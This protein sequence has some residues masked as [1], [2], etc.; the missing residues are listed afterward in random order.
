MDSQDLSCNQVRDLL[1]IAAIFKPYKHIFGTQIFT[2]R[3]F[4]T[5]PPRKQKE[6]FSNPSVV[7]VMLINFQIPSHPWKIKTISTL[8]QNML[9]YSSFF[10]WKISILIKLKICDNYFTKYVRI[11]NHSRE[12]WQSSTLWH[13][14]LIP[15]NIVQNLLKIWVSKK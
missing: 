5:F 6:V 2:L 3:I 4:L 13:K 8:T 1:Q 15:K 7:F 9:A 12:T 11:S 14:K 10:A